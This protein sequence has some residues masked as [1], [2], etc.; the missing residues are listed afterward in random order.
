M[1]I[2]F[3]EHLVFG[4]ARPGQRIEH[5][6]DVPEV[7]LREPVDI[8]GRTFGACKILIELGAMIHSSGMRSSR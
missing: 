2:L 3:F 1:S 8:I 4:P 5:V 6:L 7:D